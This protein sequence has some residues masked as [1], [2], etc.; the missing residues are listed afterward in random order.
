MKAFSLIEV[1]AAIGIL[2]GTVVALLGLLAAQSRSIE[3]IDDA[4]AAA[5]LGE[6]IQQELERLKIDLGLDGL[7]ALVPLQLAGT[8]DG[9]RMLRADGAAP[10]ADRPLNDPSLPGIALRDR[11]FLVEV[12]R[13]TDLPYAPGGGFLAVTARITWPY[14][15][16]DGPPSPDAT[17]PADDPSRIAPLAERGIVILHFALRP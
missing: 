4:H 9:R 16:P 5:R 7:A 2:A 6:N 17:D 1:V 3:A 8:R 14:R 10:A 12:T 13:Q 11:Y 15:L